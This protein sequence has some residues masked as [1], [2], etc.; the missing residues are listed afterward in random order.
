MP[1]AHVASKINLLR[2][3]NSVT[4]MPALCHTYLSLHRIKL[5]ATPDTTKPL[6]HAQCEP[7]SLAFRP[8]LPQATPYGVYNQAL[9]RRSLYSIV[10]IRYTYVLSLSLRL[11]SVDDVDSCST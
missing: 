4:D 11:S 5:R 1:R 6:R 7:S 8:H 10:I 3:R 2:R 9:S